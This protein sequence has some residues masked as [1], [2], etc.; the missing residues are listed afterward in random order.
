MGWHRRKG[1][2][3]RTRTAE[4][5]SSRRPEGRKGEEGA[6]WPVGEGLIRI[7]SRVVESH[8]LFP[9]SLPLLPLKQTIGKGRV[10]QGL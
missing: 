9:R 1:A 5:V 2:S 4:G 8:P 7:V 10:N 3:P 6:A